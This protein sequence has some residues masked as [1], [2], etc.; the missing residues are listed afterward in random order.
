MIKWGVLLSLGLFCSALHAADYLIGIEQINYY[1]HYD[2]SKGQKRGYIVDLIQLFSDKSGHRFKFVPLPVK[3]LYQAAEVDFIYPDNPL[4]RQY[5][6]P[7]VQKYF[8]EPVIFTLGSTLVR[9]Q[10][11]Y[12]SLQQFRSLAVIHGF[13]PTK[14]LELQPQYHYRLVDVPDVSSALGMVLK[15]R[16]DGASVELNVA[17]HY[18]RSRQQQDQLVIAEHLPFTQLPFLLSSVK[19]PALVAE[20]N[21][22]LLQHA[23]QVQSLKQKYQL[24]EQRPAPVAQRSE[25]NAQQLN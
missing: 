18:L 3:R 6:E 13:V 14:W 9:P 20:F 24:Q 21:Q 7:G 5:Q 19:H 22:F 17:Q 25:S 16:L 11:Q 4:W 12:I 1:P 23:T 10:Q 8:S 2:F 15:N